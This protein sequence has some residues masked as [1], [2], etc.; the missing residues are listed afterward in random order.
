MNIVK[1]SRNPFRLWDPTSEYLAWATEFSLIM[2]LVAFYWMYTLKPMSAMICIAPLT[3]GLAVQGVGN[4]KQ[5]MRM[6]VILLVGL[7]ITA[8]TAC[9]IVNY[10]V[11]MIIAMSFFVFL[12]FI[13]PKYRYLLLITVFVGE[14]V[15]FPSGWD[16][17]LQ[18]ICE[19]SVSFV[20]IVATLLISELIYGK[21]IVRSSIRYFS[22]VV[23]DL[24]LLY[25]QADTEQNLLKEIYSKHLFKEESLTRTDLYIHKIFRNDI[26]KFRYKAGQV[27]FKIEGVFVLDRFFFRSNFDCATKYIEIFTSL[28]RIFRSVNLL[29]D[30]KQHRDELKS[31]IPESEVIIEYIQSSLH[32]IVKSIRLEDF[33]LAENESIPQKWSSA[34]NALREKGNVET[35]ELTNL[36]YGF[37]FILRE[38]ALLRSEI[39]ARFQKI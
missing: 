6:S 12:S 25:T 35:P 23:H 8:F 24:F 36:C 7:A 15:D 10:P 4:F 38:I 21:Y 29:E 14:F 34:M 17:G 18:R 26:T 20:A 5:K 27:V 11:P 13:F 16:S 37:D 28:R 1:S 19:A 39:A 31:L 3:F 22:E 2:L 32:S 9:V 30:Y 33:H